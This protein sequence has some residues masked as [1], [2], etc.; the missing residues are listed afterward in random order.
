MKAFLLLLAAALGG[1]ALGP[2]GPMPQAQAPAGFKEAQGWQPARP[3]DAVPKGKWWQVFD[4]PVLN[5][6]VEQ[7]EVSNTQLRAAEARYRQAR[8]AVASARSQFF[9]ALRG[10]ARAERA[11][12]EARGR[13][14]TTYSLGLDAGWEIDVWGRV[15]GLTQSARA[16]EAASAAD[17]ENA[18]LS[19]QAELASSYFQLRVT[20]AQKSLLDDSVKALETNLR[21]TRNRYAAGVVSKA[22]VVQAEA[23]LLS[24]RS[25]SLDIRAQ[26]ASLEHAIAVLTGTP[27]AAFALEPAPFKARIPEVPAGLPS[28]LL[29]R[30]PDIAAAQRR[31]AQANAQIGVARAAYFPA[32]TLDASSGQA[33]SSIGALFDAS[34]NVWSLGLALAGTILDFGA[35]AAAVESARASY[36]ATVADYRTTVLRAFREVEDELANVRYLAEASAVQEQAASAARETV[37]LAVNQYKAGTVSFLN[38]ATAQ[39]AQLS[40]E[41]AGVQL[42]GRRLA[43]TVALIRAL[44]GS[45]Q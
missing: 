30:R 43:A 35:R 25:Q 15:R 45:W 12:G 36:D 26:R 31:V 29:E 16:G 32:V 24:V 42:L 11:G 28:T 38:V 33:S 14:D 6:L 4:D 40:E 17:V 18:K 37:A 8:S 22:D 5:G 41:R 39:A 7:V 23:Q 2:E 3:S 44:G 9:P 10:E 21:L 13:S 27:P 20:D 34:N 19:L 1:C